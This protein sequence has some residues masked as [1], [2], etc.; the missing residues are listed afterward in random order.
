MRNREEVGYGIGRKKGRCTRTLQLAEARWPQGKNDGPAYVSP[1][2]I[3]ARLLFGG[4]GDEGEGVRC[5]HASGIYRSHAK[6]KS[7]DIEC[8]CV[9]VCWRTGELILGPA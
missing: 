9:C 3:P 4:R 2:K 8:A 7:R 1:P 5:T 6:K